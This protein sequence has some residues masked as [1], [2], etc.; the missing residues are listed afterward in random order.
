MNKLH[1]L[2]FSLHRILGYRPWDLCYGN[3]VE[4][5]TDLRK[6][7]ETLSLSKRKP[8]SEEESVSGDPF[9]VLLAGD[10]L[11][12]ARAKKTISASTV[13]MSRSAFSVGV[14]SVASLKLCR[15]AYP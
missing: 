8:T 1:S 5:E 12:H 2:S 7:Q 15:H 4:P 9:D 13:S 6:L 10:V 11:R 14:L 3:C